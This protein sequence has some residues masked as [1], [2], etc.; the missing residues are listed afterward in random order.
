M[1]LLLLSLILRDNKVYIYEIS[2]EK[3]KII[4]A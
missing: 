3:K 1:N 4:K 2:K